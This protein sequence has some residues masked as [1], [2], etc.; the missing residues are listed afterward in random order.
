MLKR[1]LVPVDGS[2][3][4]FNALNFAMAIGCK[5][6]SEIIV[7]NVEVPY[8]FT[9]LPKR[10]PKN[11]IE[12]AEMASAPKEPT[13]LEAAKSM[14]DKAGYKKIMLLETIS[15]DPAERIVE[16][17]AQREADMVVM[18]N[19]GLGSWAGL[20]M[21]SVSSRVSQSVDCPVIIVK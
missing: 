18:G 4:A 12:A 20:I 10:Q 7:V 11:A 17:V 1:I 19:R 13:A 2:E 21:G 8:D 15:T 5:F 9:K 16:V 14:A 6:G 3:T